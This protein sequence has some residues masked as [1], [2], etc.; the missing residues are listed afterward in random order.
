VVRTRDPQAHATRREA[1]LDAAQLLMQTRGYEQM[2]VQ[3][4]LDA[5]G[6]SKGAFYH[7]FGSKADL[8][9][10][11]VERL[12]D[13]GVAQVSHGIDDPGRSALEKFERVFTG[14]ADYK[15]ER[16]ELILGFMRAW[17]SDE[18]AVVR[19]HFR[20]GLV[21][22]LQPVMTAIVRQGVAEGSFRVAS[23]EATSRVL[24]SLIQGLNEDATDLF[25]AL[26]SGEVAF[27]FLEARLLSYAQAFERILD[28]A[29]G[30]LKFADPSVIRDWYQWAQARK[31]IA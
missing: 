15:A 9:E 25:L 20:R 30:S 2:S 11:V 27:E 28:A 14:L 22:R 1:F 5:M 23:P 29:P 6:T 31:E 4:V 18:N 12:V 10:A 17:L 8:L 3:D 19:E 7:Y 21:R 24:I 26:D 13:A 16:R